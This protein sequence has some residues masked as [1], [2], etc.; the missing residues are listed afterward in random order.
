MRLCFMH[1]YG[2]SH[3]LSLARKRHWEGTSR[4]ALELV[5]EHPIDE[6]VDL[7]L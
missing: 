2:L 7:P 1:T 3:R 6:R 4:Q 5:R